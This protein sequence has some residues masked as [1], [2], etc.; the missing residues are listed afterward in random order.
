MFQLGAV[1][2]AE[3]FIAFEIPL[4]QNGFQLLTIPAVTPQEFIHDVERLNLLPKR[5][6]REDSD[7]SGDGV[8]VLENFFQPAYQP[9]PQV[10]VAVLLFFSIRQPCEELAHSLVLV[11]QKVSMQILQVLLSLQK[12]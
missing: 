8:L 10:P 11:R 1:L 6:F 4:A 7:G 2:Y 5:L 3:A 9:L 12:R